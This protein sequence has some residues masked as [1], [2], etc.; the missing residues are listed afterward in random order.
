MSPNTLIAEPIKNLVTT[1]RV[2]CGLGATPVS[3]DFARVILDSLKDKSC[4]ERVPVTL[5]D[6]VRSLLDLPF[7]TLEKVTVSEMR[8]LLEEYVIY[9]GTPEGV[10]NPHFRLTE[11]KMA[12]LRA[13][14][15]EQ[16]GRQPKGAEDKEAK[17][18][19]FRVI[20]KWKRPET[21]DYLL[22]K[23]VAVRFEWIKEKEESLLN[24]F[25]EAGV[26]HKLNLP[27]IRAKAG[28]NEKGLGPKNGVTE[29]YGLSGW[30]MFKIPHDRSILSE[31]DTVDKEGKPH[32]TTTT[33]GRGKDRI[34]VLKLCNTPL[35]LKL[36][37]EEDIEITSWL[38]KRE[39]QKSLKQVCVKEQTENRRPFNFVRSK[40]AA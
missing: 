13:T 8:L 32:I 6:K 20:E 30:I 24:L 9:A 34:E 7:K 18:G 12:P 26:P 1:F 5:C 21:R 3:L 40:K 17:R 36:L 15:V 31:I 39:Y 11:E 14:N 19:G 35:V 33:F 28:L 38:G 27:G 4:F 29:S 37:L 25:R 10:R 22:L 23:T 16:H 2:G